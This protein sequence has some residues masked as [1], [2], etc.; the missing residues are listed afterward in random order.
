[1][2]SKKSSTIH[3]VG[4]HTDTTISKGEVFYYV[5]ME[6]LSSTTKHRWAYVG[7]N[8]W[9]SDVA[10]LDYINHSCDA[11]TTFDIT[12]KIPRL[13]ALRDILPNEEITIDY[14]QTEQNG[15]LFPCICSSHTCKGN[16]SCII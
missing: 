4:M 7:N 16:F 1:M 13:I 6:I 2:L 15:A 5:P 10:V 12:T 8:I 9:V 3:G 14:N 11:N